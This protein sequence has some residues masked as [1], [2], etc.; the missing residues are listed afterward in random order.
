MWLIRP[1][2]KP[3]EALSSWLVRIAAANG[4]RLHSFTTDHWPGLAL[5]T[6]DIDHLA[7]SSVLETLA[8]RTATTLSDARATTFSQYGG[9]LFEGDDPI[10]HFSYVRPLGVFHRLRRAFGQQF[11]PACLATDPQPYFRLTWRLSL[12]PVCTHH[13][14]ILL[15]RCGKCG[16]PVL[17]HRGGIATCHSCHTPL[18]EM[19]QCDADA[20]VLAF[21]SINAAILAGH[22]V[23]WPWPL[24]GLHPLLYFRLIMCLASTLLLGKRRDAFRTHVSAFLREPL[25]QLAHDRKVELRFLPPEMAHDA[26]RGVAALLVGWPARFVGAAQEAGL[27]YSWAQKD[28]EPSRVPYAYINP[29]RTYLKIDGNEAKRTYR[30]RA[31]AQADCSR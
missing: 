16:Q 26:L 2:P 11:C 27:W 28:L 20:M 15:D 23:A 17:P 1:K 4:Q 22:P 3:H 31:S 13:G 5:W 7:P 30:S 14:K 24:L 19:T 9:I 29:V 21:Q 12:F 8:K 10:T 6:R 25:P 18:G